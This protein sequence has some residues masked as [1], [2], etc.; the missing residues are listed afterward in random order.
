MSRMQVK[1]HLQNN[2]DTTELSFEFIS[3]KSKKEKKKKKNTEKNPN[4]QNLTKKA[5]EIFASF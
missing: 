3:Q 4:N 2:L 5:K 1:Y